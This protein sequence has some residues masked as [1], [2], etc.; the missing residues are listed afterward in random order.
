MLKRLL[1]RSAIAFSSVVVALLVVEVMLRVFG[2]A[3]PSTTDPVNYPGLRIPYSTVVFTKE[4]Y[5]SRTVNSFGIID[6]E[7]P[8]DD[9]SDQ[10]LFR[11]LLLGDS[12]TAANEV[13][14]EFA[15]D[16]IIEDLFAEEN[17]NLEI[18]NL[19]NAGFGTLEELVRYRFVAERV[20][21]DA[22][23]IAFTGS[24]ITENF[25]L[26]HKLVE[27]SLI[28]TYGVPL[29]SE[30]L[31][32]LF[33]KVKQHSALVNQLGIRLYMFT[34]YLHSRGFLAKGM[35]AS[36]SSH[37]CEE[38]LEYEYRILDHFNR[39]AESHKAEL[40]LYALPHV[41]N[42]FGDGEYAEYEEE[43]IAICDSV[44]ITYLDLFNDLWNYATDHPDEVLL[45][46]LN[47]KLGSGHFSRQGHE[48]LAELLMPYLRQDVLKAAVE[49]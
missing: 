14:S 1:F 19:A 40:Y 12:Y 10:D 4:G 36:G 48:V 13:D 25:G 9:D 46:F 21:H 23:L 47:S 7:Y 24:D 15:Y 6:R 38:D 32:G 8:L 41:Q 2:L 26:A 18:W 17:I 42:V 33:R 34:N 39:L 3:A 30:G 16:N 49:E 22:V 5:S 29:Q 20:P 31:R 44:G 37:S 45:G 27:D 11:I 43:I 35:E 28:T